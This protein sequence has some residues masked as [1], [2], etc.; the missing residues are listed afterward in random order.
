MIRIILVLVSH[1][2]RWIA[3]GPTGE[4]RAG[5]SIVKWYWRPG[6]STEVP[7]TLFG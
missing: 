4:I 2:W 6:S 5:E 7:L 1:I 3:S